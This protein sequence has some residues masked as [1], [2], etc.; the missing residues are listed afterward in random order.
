MNANVINTDGMPWEQMFPPMATDL[1]HQ[2]V[3]QYT[4]QLQKIE[5]VR[6]LTTDHGLGSVLQYYLDGN[7]AQERIT[8][9][10]S[11]ML[12]HKGAVRA[13]DADYW[14]KALLATDVLQV[15]PKARR[16]EWYNQIRRMETPPFTYESVR[17]T[18]AD[19]LASR[20]LFLSERVDGIFRGLSHEHITNRPEGF[21]KR[22]IMA[23]IIDGTGWPGRQADYIHDLRC[24]IAKFM[25]R[26]DPHDNLSRGAVR[27]AWEVRGQWITL[28]GGALRLRV[29][30]KG[31]GH[32]E[33]HP[34]MAWRLNAIL[35]SMHPQAIPAQHR[36]PAAK[37]A[38][39]YPLM[40]D[41][42]PF[43]VLQVLNRI[44]QG[45]DYCPNATNRS[46]WVLVP[47]AYQFDLDPADKHVEAKAVEILQALG[48][49][50]DRHLFRF[51]YPA[52]PVI[53]Q[54]VQTGT[55]PDRYS[56]QFYPTP[57]DLADEAAALLDV[58]HGADVLEPSAGCGALADAVRRKVEGKA[59]AVITCVEVAPLQCA[60][61]T[62][63]EY[64]VVQD[65][66]I[67]W[68]AARTWQ[69]QAVIMNPPFDQGRWKNHLQA[70][71]RLV[72]PGG[73]L[74]AILPASARAGTDLE[75]SVREWHGPYHNR[76]A[77]TGVSVIILKATRLEP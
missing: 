17:A 33:V 50:R 23:Y 19:M 67:S 21:G 7:T 64:K 20:A 32:L 54:V 60:V 42:V 53:T 76:F 69:Y 9:K 59:L 47:N 37:Q 1:V 70:A 55:V 15:M 28:D 12:N 66:F 4:L 44:K 6:T 39:E 77:G 25:G 63:K 45:H 51:D 73:N 3:A 36:Q 22:M 29:Y 41:L 5:Q 8:L 71:W 31:T 30:K 58:P 65:D 40:H 57:A 74:V 46:N 2:L 14:N 10:A 34:D 72:A 68:A 24:V 61:L 43:Q 35:A 38:K 13:L 16:D 11:E 49:V 26:D 27:E 52:A 75:N 56:H 62:A 18:L 48:A